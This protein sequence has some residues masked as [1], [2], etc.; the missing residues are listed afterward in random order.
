MTSEGDTTGVDVG[1]E[2][3][4]TAT[5]DVTLNL[6]HYAIVWSVD[7]EAVGTVLDQE[8]TTNT[9]TGV[10]AGV[11]V[12]TAEIKEVDYVGGERT[13]VSLDTPITDT[14]TITVSAV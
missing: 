9:L 13:L 6:H 2:L 11:V 8:G 12:V 3:V 5:P 14:I 7:D 10:S 1:A 4:L